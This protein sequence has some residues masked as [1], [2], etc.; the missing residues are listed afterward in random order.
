MINQ[1]KLKGLFFILLSLI[2]SV[3]ILTAQKKIKKITVSG[4][5]TDTCNNPLV[6]AM[7]LID[8]KKTQIHTDNRGYYKIRIRPE[9]IEISVLSHNYMVK[10]ELI[11]GR[12]S[13]NISLREIDVSQR[14][15]QKTGE[16]KESV[17]LGY[18]RIDSKKTAISVS[19]SDVLDVSGSE[20][21]A[22][23]NIYEMIQGRFPGVDVNGQKIRI[24][25]VNT[26]AGNN[27]PMFVV[28]GNPVNSIDHIIPNK[29]QS[30][31]VLKG[32][33]TTIYGSRGVNGVIV[34]TLK[35]NT[36]KTE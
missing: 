3:N 4:Y 22:Y 34:I 27:D 36:S 20:Y 32:T 2:F 31:T 18:R 8:K 30:I 6:G 14:I 13:I 35:K 19:K 10:P 5:V 17:D 15:G 24:R 33:A 28:D 23:R 16:S 25:G 11:G 29:V 12:T 26:L 21:S 1:M 9:A 7:I